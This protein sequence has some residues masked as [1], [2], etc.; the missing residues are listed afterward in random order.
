MLTISLFI[1][2]FKILTFY[3]L[4]LN[5]VGLVYV[6]RWHTHDIYHFISTVSLRGYKG[7]YDIKVHKGGPSGAVIY[8]RHITLDRAG[9]SMT[10]HVTGQG[11]GD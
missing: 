2:L 8:T 3:A 1:S 5:E 6:N 11:M 7:E 4:Q 10:I 9:Q